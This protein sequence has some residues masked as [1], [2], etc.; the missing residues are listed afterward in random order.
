MLLMLLDRSDSEA[1]KLLLQYHRC[2]DLVFSVM[3]L[4]HT[5]MAIVYL[6]SDSSIDGNVSRAALKNVLMLW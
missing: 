6:Q 2:T 1:T 4:W 5:G 3:R